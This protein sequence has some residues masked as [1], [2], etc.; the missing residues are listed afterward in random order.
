M[1]RECLLYSQTTSKALPT[2]LN[3]TEKCTNV[4]V[5]LPQLSSVA[6]VYNG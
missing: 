4:C 5:I 2:L 6:A 1:L 3:K